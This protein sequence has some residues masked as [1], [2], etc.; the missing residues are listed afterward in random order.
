MHVGESAHCLE[1]ADMMSSSVLT[2]RS[3]TEIPER[4]ADNTDDEE[5]KHRVKNIKNITY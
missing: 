2:D 5:Q 4:G 1:L 3:L